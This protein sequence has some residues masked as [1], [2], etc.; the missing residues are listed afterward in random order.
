MEMHSP[1]C[2][3][4]IHWTNFTLFLAHY[5]YIYM[6]QTCTTILRELILEVN[7]EKKPSYKNTYENSSFDELPYRLKNVKN[8]M[9]GFMCLWI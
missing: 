6:I 3:P 4:I 5:I 8:K 2:S 9:G 7:E 1:K